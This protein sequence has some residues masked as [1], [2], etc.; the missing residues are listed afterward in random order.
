MAAGEGVQ[1][2]GLN[3]GAGHKLVPDVVLGVQRVCGE[4]L[5]EAGTALVEPEVG[6]PL[7]GHQVPE[8]LVGRLVA[9]HDGHEFLQH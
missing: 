2:E 1:F 9:N 3:H 8:P 7:H 5:H 4:V 6:P